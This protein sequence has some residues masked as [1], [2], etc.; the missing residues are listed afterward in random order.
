MLEYSQNAIEIMLELAQKII[1]PSGP[2]K[3][4]LSTIDGDLIETAKLKRQE[5]TTA[6][7]LEKASDVITADISQLMNTLRGYP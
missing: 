3:S 7:Q 2:S 1:Y 5:E 4:D 6:Q